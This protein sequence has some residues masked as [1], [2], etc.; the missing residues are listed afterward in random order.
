[1]RMH[2]CVHGS[3]ASLRVPIGSPW[4]LKTMRLPCPSYKHICLPFLLVFLLF[5]RGEGFDRL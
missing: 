2:D 1:M 5:S 4:L 3:I